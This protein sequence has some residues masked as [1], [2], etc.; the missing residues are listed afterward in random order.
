MNK[1]KSFTWPGLKPGFSALRTEVLLTEPPG[2]A[3]VICGFTNTPFSRLNSA[4]WPCQNHNIV[5]PFSSQLI[6]IFSFGYI[7]VQKK[8][9]FKAENMP[10]LTFFYVPQHPQ[11][12]GRWTLYHA[13]YAVTLILKTRHPLSPC[14]LFRIPRPVNKLWIL[15]SCFF[16]KFLTQYS[17]CNVTTTNCYSKYIYF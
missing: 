8:I 9:L 10:Y 6:W 3:N 5:T 1:T 7:N 2:Q 4:S 16:S 11:S 12:Y 14:L 13:L 15:K 17:F